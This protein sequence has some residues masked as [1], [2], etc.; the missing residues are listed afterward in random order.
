MSVRVGVIGCGVQGRVHLEQYR[1]IDGVEIAA[2]CDLDPER[3]AAAA[4]DYGAA[5]R[6]TDYRDLLA[7]GGLDLVSVCTMPDTHRAI[8]TLALQAGAH[9]VCEKPMALNA[10]EAAQM[11][12]VAAAARRLL[13]VGLN[14]RYM[15][16]AGWLHRYV[17]EGGI[18]ALTH[19]HVWTLDPD[20]PWWGKHYV[21]ALAGGGVVAST[22]VHLLDLAL[23]V[24]GYPAPAAVSATTARLFPGKR[25]LTA[26]SAAARAAYDVEDQ[27]AALVRFAG[28]ASLTLHA[29]WCH[30]R[31]EGA[32]GFEMV[33]TAGAVAWPLRVVAERAGQPVDLTPPAVPETSWPDSVRWQL[34]DVVRRIQA[35]EEVGLVTPRQALTLQRL[36]D[37]IYES[38]AQGREV[39]L[40]G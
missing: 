5:R 18:G 40:A 15:A 17:A 21:K 9:V 24:A 11:V 8:A 2:V 30:D 38:A 25:G 20:I 14:M 4:R 1:Q 26:P 28:G 39:A 23:Y 32:R 19:V 29:A 36:I 10:A 22:A 3:A 13:T 6:A 33:G 37:G 34:A 31:V 27:A 35:G 7:A 12:E 16:A